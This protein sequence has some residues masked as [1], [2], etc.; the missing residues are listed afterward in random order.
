MLW[1]G[2][3]NDTEDEDDL[4]TTGNKQLK[5]NTARAGK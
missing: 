4:R 3:P 5:K 2:I 1:N